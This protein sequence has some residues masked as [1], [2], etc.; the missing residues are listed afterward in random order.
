MGILRDVVDVVAGTV[1]AIVG[2]ATGIVSAAVGLAVH[3]VYHGL[4]VLLDVFFPKR[5]GKKIARAIIT[6]AAFAATAYIFILGYKL[7]WPVKKAIGWIRTADA[8][9]TMWTAALPGVIGK[10]LK[11]IWYA[12][13]LP[14]F[15]L[16]RSAV[17]FWLWKWSYAIGGLIASLEAGKA[18]RARAQ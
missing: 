2:V 16:A 3:W 9:V 5:V 12:T 7:L 1:K 6:G 13:G 14:I 8:L 18:A 10:P 15:A 17:G 4:V 11:G